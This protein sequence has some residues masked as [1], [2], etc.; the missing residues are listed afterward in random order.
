MEF[1][2]RVLAIA[3][4]PSAA[5]AERKKAL[6][7]AGKSIFDFGT[8]D[9]IEPTAAFIRE[10]LAK[11]VP[12]ISQYP[13]VKG[14]PE[15]R[16]AA[17]AYLARRFGATLDPENEI[18]P[19]TGSKEAIFNITNVMIGPESAR[20]TVIGAVPGYFVM[21]RSSIVG[22]ATYYPVQLT[23]Q[24]AWMLELSELP[25]SVLRSSAIA[26]I[27]YPH[28]PTG[29]QC[30]RE[31][32]KRQV[33]TAKKYDILLCSDE[34]Y[35]DLYLQGE[36][37]PSV[38]EIATKGVL[39]FHSCSKRSG[40]TAY[41]SGFMAGDRDVL[42]IYSDY[43]NTLGVATPIYTQRAATAAWGD[44]AHVA[45]RREIFRRKRDLFRT[46][47]QE[48][49]LKVTPSDATFYLWMETPRGLSGAQYAA[50]LLEE[51]IVVSPGEFFGGS[52][53]N[54]VRAALV[55]S[56]EDCKRA[57]EVWRRVHARVVA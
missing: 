15:L 35:V 22:S 36:P 50:A 25:E 32:L 38:L 39:A 54:Y 49:G 40:M 23:P 19:C 41:R 17:A 20:K 6:T 56:L 4:Y 10:A 21:E 16:K 37:P 7:A 3:E 57:T 8:G 43:R 30:S 47:L 33:E 5:L 31:Y 55:P 51:G 52:Q 53:T 29:A 46:F 24:N 9:P 11:G 26:W 2:K 1:N 28:N 34:C 42:K 13:S 14:T 44:D 48:I 27:N 12:E 45:E 18:L